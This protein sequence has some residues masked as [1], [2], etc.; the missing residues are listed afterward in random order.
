MRILLDECVDEKLRHHFAGHDCQ[1]V[2][3]AG[4]AAISNGRLLAAAEA[5]GFDV[6]VTTDQHIPEQQNLVE[7][8]LAI[9]ILCGETNRLAE[10]TRLVP[11]ALPAIASI[12]PGQVVRIR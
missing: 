8:R 4:L 2:R 12:D 9:V 10:L 7:R 6:M 1:T 11:A 5:A 3:Y